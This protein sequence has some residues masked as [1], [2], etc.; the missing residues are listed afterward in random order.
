VDLLSSF[1]FSVEKIAALHLRT[2]SPI[3]LFLFLFSDG[4]GELVQE[5]Y[6]LLLGH[7]LLHQGKACKA[8]LVII[9]NIIIIIVYF[10]DKTKV[11]LNSSRFS[12]IEL[13]GSLKVII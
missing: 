11:Q 6:P 1:A 7:F 13:A 8:I 5:V 12:K 2:L 10:Q 4:T 9:I 3:L